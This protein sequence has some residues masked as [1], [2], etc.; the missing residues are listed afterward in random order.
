MKYIINLQYSTEVIYMPCFN[1]I[2]L[3][4]N[5]SVTIL[6]ITMIFKIRYYLHPMFRYIL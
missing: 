1:I 5:R 2:S 6:S 4:D 3:C